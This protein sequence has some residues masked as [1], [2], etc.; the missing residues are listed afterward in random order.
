[1]CTHTLTKTHN[2]VS[3]ANQ[4]NETITRKAIVGI[5][6]CRHVDSAPWAQLH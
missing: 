6:Y 1:M 3:V 2:P 5:P 4:D